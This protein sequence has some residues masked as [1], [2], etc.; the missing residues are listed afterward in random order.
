V[1][2][3]E[4]CSG[5]P[6][7]VPTTEEQLRAWAA[8]QKSATLDLFFCDPL[9]A[10]TTQKHKKYKGIS[11]N[12]IGKTIKAGFSGVKPKNRFIALSTLGAGGIS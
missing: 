11:P 1:P 9:P 8:S 12:T 5:T 4:T 2:R 3:P 7:T 6:T 10:K